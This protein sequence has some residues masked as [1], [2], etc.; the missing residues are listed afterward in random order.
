MER[1]IR[2]GE[3][4]T[5]KHEIEKRAYDQKQGNSRDISFSRLP[6][7]GARKRENSKEHRPASRHIKAR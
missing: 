4:K 2:R 5:H 1:N 7:I 6:D 3:K